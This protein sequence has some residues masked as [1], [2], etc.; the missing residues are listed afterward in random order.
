MSVDVKTEIVIDRPV[1]E[2]AAYASDPANAAG[3][4]N[5]TRAA[6]AFTIVLVRPSAPELK[7]PAL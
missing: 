1:D 4:A 5:P 6:A 3:F 2:V 7:L